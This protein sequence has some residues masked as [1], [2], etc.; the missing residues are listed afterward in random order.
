MQ[1]KI[2]ALAV[3]AVASTAAFAQSNVTVYGVAD[4]YV[5]GLTSGSTKATVVGS[6]GLAGSRIGFKG[7]EDLGNGTKALFTIEYAVAMDGNAGLGA[8]VPNYNPASS[9]QTRQA[10]VGLTGD[11]GT[12]VA[13]RLQSL[14]Y[15]H[16][17]AFNPSFGTAADTTQSASN[18]GLATFSQE[19]LDN[20]VAYVAPKLGD[21]TLAGAYTS[22]AAA[23]DVGAYS[24]MTR[25]YEASA[26]WAN[27]PAAV[28]VVYRNVIDT[29]VAVAGNGNHS[30]NLGGSY[31]FGV[32]KLFAQATQQQNNHDSDH[33]VTGSQ[34]G[35]VVPV[36]AK[37]AVILSSAQAKLD[38][39]EN[40]R[41]SNAL[42]YKHSLSART[43]L[44][45]GI[46]SS[47]GSAG[48]T[49]SELGVSSVVNG[50][51]TAALVGMN[52]SF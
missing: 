27:G 3:A 9:T 50:T 33:K 37:G 7:T 28:G 13:G 19:R 25:A 52:H 48:A 5:G 40:K 43:A 10:F 39:N 44:Y 20:A 47:K 45:G 23:S 32:A 6:G 41:V 11:Y 49:A 12:V 8:N 2:I 30:Y 29:A 17:A 4:A 46:A 35:A 26:L 1:K 51:A 18:L 42:L 34:I 38:V 22:N 16:N 15:N 21:V 24:A 31:D 14:V 36:S